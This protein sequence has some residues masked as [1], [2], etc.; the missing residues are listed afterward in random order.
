M[1]LNNVVKREAP[2]ASNDTEELTEAQMSGE[3]RN[4]CGCRP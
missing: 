4:F 3:V 1:I 2:R